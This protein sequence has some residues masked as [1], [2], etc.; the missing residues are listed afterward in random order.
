MVDKLDA[1]ANHLDEIQK[2]IGDATSGFVFDNPTEEQRKAIG[3]SCANMFGILTSSDVKHESTEMDPKTPGTAIVTLRFPM[4][5]MEKVHVDLKRI[6]QQPTSGQS[7]DGPE[8]TK[9]ADAD[10]MLLDAS[11][12]NDYNRP[13]TS[14]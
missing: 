4:K 7:P 13:Q 12:E 3:E 9:T 2:I 1:A 10:F 11:V 5:K 8:L 6:Q 14:P